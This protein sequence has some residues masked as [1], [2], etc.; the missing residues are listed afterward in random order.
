MCV[1]PFQVFPDKRPASLRTACFGL[2][3][4][5]CLSAEAVWYLSN[6]RGQAEA[7]Y[8]KCVVGL[9][10]AGDLQYATQESRRVFLYLFTTTDR[11]KRLERVGAIRKA[12]LTVSLLIGRFLML[13]S[14]R[15]EDDAIRSFDE[16]WNDYLNTRDDIVALTLQGR[17]NEAMAL[18]NGTALQT[19]K[20]AEYYIK[21]L[22]SKLTRAAAEESEHVSLSFMQAIVA[23]IALT[24]TLSAFTIMLAVNSIRYR[25][26]FESEVRIRTQMAEQETRFRSLIE[27][28]LDV[29]AILR[30]DGVIRYLSPSI[31]RVLGYAPEEMIG[32]NAF[33]FV[34]PE[35]RD[36]VVERM[37]RAKSGPEPPLN[38][39]FR[40]LDEAGGWRVL[41]AF[42]RNLADSPE[43][44]GVVINCRDVTERH[45]AEGRLAD[46]NHS[47]EKALSAARDATELKSRF[48]AN[49]S[50]E[51]RTP[52]NG[53]I[54]MSELLLTT[55]LTGEQ[56]EYAQA[57]YRSS[58]ALTGIIN[59]ILDISK[60]E[61]G[62]LD[63]ENVPFG[64]HDVLRDI[65]ALMGPMAIEKGLAFEWRIEPGVPNRIFGDA[66]RFRQVVLNLLSNAIKFTPAGRVHLLATAEPAGHEAV[67]FSCA[68]EDTGIGIAPDQ[69]CNVFDSFRQGDSSTTRRYGGTGLG[70][71]I[72]QELARRLNG[73]ITVVSEQG[74]GSVF[75]F[76]VTA[77]VAPDPVALAPSA[78]PAPPTATA[79]GRVLVAEDNAVN[80]RLASRILAKAGHY[81]EVVSDGAAAE[82]EVRNGNWDVVLMDLQMPVMDGL[83]ATRR[84]RASGLDIPIIALTAN[85]MR[86]DRE[87]CLDAGMSDY[88]AKPL[89]AAEVLTKVDECLRR[90]AGA[91]T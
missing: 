51:I 31:E 29:I 55:D 9:S 36:G 17:T 60:I 62:R 58:G 37:R 11:A 64:L 65:V 72:S 23:L 10:V 15:R 70:L 78:T 3:A 22:E 42:G 84:I 16:S 24:L 4:L 7:L 48:L 44:G 67:R 13:K 25:R 28:A 5:V 68:I 8:Q 79:A 83:E 73:D 82:R 47:L 34:H 80:A 39:S 38:V 50:H 57:V 30:P 74:R 49:M 61:S 71:A 91:L 2:L 21:Q 66:C 86:G 76:V 59:D 90:C 53:I 81:V 56:R 18:E 85:A 63:L 43:V 52:M 12:D 26:L 77:A 33:D 27:N 19:F 75:R 20:T 1:R 6:A 88:L 46:T 69:L 89:V 40:F 35:E 32:R 14:G 87:C 45:E 54:G 41:E